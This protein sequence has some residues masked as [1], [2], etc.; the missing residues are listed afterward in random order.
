VE[1]LD[2]GTGGFHLMGHMESYPYV[3]MIDATLDGKPAGTI[4]LITP[5]FATDFPTALSA[6]DIGL[7]DM[8][9]SL[10]LLDRLP[11]IHL[12]TIS[13]DEIQPMKTTLSDK[14]NTAL[15]ALKSNVFKLLEKL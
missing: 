5:K 13:I 15:P 1:L 12:F 2:G 9:E 14:V 4:R 8:I 10:I 3:I 11:E 6:H 7:K